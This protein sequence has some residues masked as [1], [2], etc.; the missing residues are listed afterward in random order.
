[1]KYLTLFIAMFILASCG[2]EPSAQSSDDLTPNVSEES[3]TDEQQPVKYQLKYETLDE[4]GDY[5][6]LEALAPHFGDDM[7]YTDINK[8]KELLTETEKFVK[9]YPTDT[10]APAALFRAGGAARHMGEWVK[11]Q[12]L[13]RQA[14]TDYPDTYPAPLALFHDA[15][16]ADQVLND[17]DKALEMYDIFLARYPDNSFKPEIQK[18]KDIL[19]ME[20]DEYIKRAKEEN[21]SNY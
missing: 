5:S 13:F 19:F 8:A 9:A 16:I 3:K 11:A 1:M 10:R 2:D 12:Q 21:Q 20:Q 7:E 14:W 15:Y 4:N 18:L 17:K 6:K